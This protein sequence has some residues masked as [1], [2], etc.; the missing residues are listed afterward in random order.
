M[1]DAETILWSR[2]HRDAVWKFRRQHPI[3]RYIADF[4]C[5]AAR[6][7]VEVDGATHSSDAQI[8]Y[9]RIRTASLKRQGW[10]VVRVANDDVY[11][12]LSAVLDAI[13][14]EIAHAS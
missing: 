8:A 11:R 6:I 1:T 9:D 12:R 5:I 7:V 13:Y 10:R 2:L 4:A 3:G 14:D